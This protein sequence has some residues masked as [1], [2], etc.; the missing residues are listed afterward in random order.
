MRF[1]SRSALLGSTAL[2]GALAAFATAPAQAQMYSTGPGTYIS[3]EGRYMWNAGDKV[4]NYFYDYAGGTG[5]YDFEPYNTSKAAAEKGWGGKV[6]LGYRFS[7][8]WDVGVGV[9]GGWLKGKD[10]TLTYNYNVASG[11]AALPPGGAGDS[12]KTKLW[13]TTVDFEA[14]YNMPM[15]GMSNFRLYGGL[16]FAYLNQ[17]AKGTLENLQYD[18]TYYNYSGK[19]KTTFTGVGPRIGANGTFG[20]GNSGFNIFGGVSGALL[21][22]KY[23]DKRHFS[24][25]GT[26]AATG[27][28]SYNDRKKTKIVPNLEGE[29][30]LGYNFNAG[31]GGTSV[32]LQIGYRGE[33]FF[34]A[35]TK[36]HIIAPYHKEPANGDDIFHGPFVRLIATFGAPAAA[37]VAAPPPPAPPRTA[38]SFIVF[39][40]FDRSNITA[41]AQATIN[42]AV[43]AAKAGNSTRITLTGHTD[44]SGSEQYNQALSVRRGE[45]V[46]AAMIRGGIP[47]NAI[48][49]IGR[50][51]SQPLVPTADGVRE[52]QN[53]RV[54]I[55]I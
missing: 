13:Y 10:N 38:K 34:G 37:P 50:G 5:P 42:D 20:I 4:K 43:A 23:K 8:N 17:T 40:D 16:R 18:G 11:I 39:F 14:G 29:I 54:E 3:L 45:A 33:A 53:R 55:V 15:G 6:M 12:I 7:N 35:A 19:R 31:S 44:R 21:I 41:Q 47:A 28:Y 1:A 52:P 49:V 51:E 9:A 24:Y 26:N 30:G 2:V 46:K 32:G 48:V 25:V 22:G 36:G 27:S